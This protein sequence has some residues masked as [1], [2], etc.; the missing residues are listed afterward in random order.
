MFRTDHFINDNRPYKLIASFVRLVIL[1]AQN[2]SKSDA[3]LL[4]SEVLQ[5]TTYSLYM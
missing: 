3:F 5:R 2:K 1:E 4:S